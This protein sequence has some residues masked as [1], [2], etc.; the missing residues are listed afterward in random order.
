MPKARERF[1][2]ILARP[3]CT[4]AAPIFDPLSA[5]IAD[6]LGWEVCKLSGSIGK[7]ANLAV[8]DGVPLSNISDLVDLCWRINRVTDNCLIVDADEGGGNALNVYRTVRELEA[9]GA[10]AIE[11]EGKLG[12]SPFG[13]DESRHSLLIPLE[14]QVD[15]LQD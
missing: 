2:Q 10:V 7:F 13:E 4:L 12:P 9:A 8:P 11:H 6:M 14:E 3:E 15:K 5:R 1:R